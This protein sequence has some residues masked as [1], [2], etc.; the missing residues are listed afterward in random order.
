MLKGLEVLKHLG[1][2]KGRLGLGYSLMAAWKDPS[3]GHKV[4][5]IE[6]EQNGLKAR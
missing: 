6:M 2:L 3:K 5:E 1:V 4:S